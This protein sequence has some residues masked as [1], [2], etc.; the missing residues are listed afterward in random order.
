VIV[1]LVRFRSKLPDQEVQAIFEERSYLYRSVPGLVQK[2]YLRFGETGEFGAV[3]LW[4][5][6]D[7]RVHFMETDLARTIPSVYQVEGA[8]SSETAEVTLVVQPDRVTAP[9]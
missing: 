7:D 2:I 4:E 6:E 1:S 9:P 8:A 3:Y 5:S